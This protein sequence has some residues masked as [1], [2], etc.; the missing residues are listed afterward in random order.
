MSG[1]ND[2]VASLKPEFPANY[3]TE[4]KMQEAQFR[5]LFTNVP[6][7]EHVVLVFRATWNPND[8]QEFPGRVYVTQKNLYF[9]SHHLGLVL[10]TSASLDTIDEVT[11]APGKD[12]DFLF[13]HLKESA[14]KTDYTRITIKTFLEPLRLLQA[15]LNY[16][17]INRQQRSAAKLEQ[18][19]EALIKLEKD[20]PPP[21]SSNESW[22]EVG[23]NGDRYNGSDSQGFS[24]HKSRREQRDLK[25]AIHVE[26]G[27]HP[28]PKAS[29]KF[30]LPSQPI[31]Y[32]PE[33]MDRKPVERVFEIS[34]KSL[35]DR[36]STR[37]NSS[38]WE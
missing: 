32:V 1:L 8:Q 19:M 12:C 13:L 29:T 15:R 11:A 37:L 23:Y 9:Y 17:V 3:P 34:P 30:Q 10:I 25:R 35:L 14:V 18:A 27:L 24:R 33:G 22:E 20:I 26:G 2:V 36:K 7:D 6:K 4:L 38:H 5:M 21:D 28:M 31:V 16:L